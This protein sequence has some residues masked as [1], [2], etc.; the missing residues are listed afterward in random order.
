MIGRSNLKSSEGASAKKS[1]KG[2]VS[3]KNYNAD[4]SFAAPSPFL[5][6]ETSKKINEKDQKE[7]Q[8]DPKRQSGSITLPG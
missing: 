5:G 4:L 1:S 8:R 2:R 7:Q 3:S 6:P